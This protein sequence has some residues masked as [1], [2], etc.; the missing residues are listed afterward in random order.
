MNIFSWEAF[1]QQNNSF[2]FTVSCICSSFHSVLFFLRPFFFS[3]RGDKEGGFSCFQKVGERTEFLWRT[4]W[5]T[6]WGSEKVNVAVVSGSGLKNAEAV[7]FCFSAANS[8]S[9]HLSDS[10]IWE[11]VQRTI[12]CLRTNSKENSEGASRIIKREKFVSSVQILMG[13]G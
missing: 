3:A 1:V 7:V 8:K 5:W 13:Y 9:S 4:L 10:L 11:K 6:W 2:S 12:K